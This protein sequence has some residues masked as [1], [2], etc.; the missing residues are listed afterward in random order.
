MDQLKRCCCNFGY[1]NLMCTVCRHM[2][3]NMCIDLSHHDSVIEHYLKEFDNHDII[4]C[5]RCLYSYK[6]IYKFIDKGTINNNE[7]ISE[8]DKFI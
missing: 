5:G 2:V 6:L 8:S 1:N 4:I 7:I 3:C